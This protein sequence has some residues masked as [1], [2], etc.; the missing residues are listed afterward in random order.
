MIPKLIAFYL[1]QF[2]PFKE[3]DEWW[4]KGFTE[5]TNVT[6]ARPLFAGHYQPHLPTDLGFYDLRVRD[7]RREQIALAKAHGIHGFCYYYYWFSGRRLLDRPVDDMLADRDSDMPFC[8]CWANE[9]WTRT[10][11]G[12]ESDILIAQRHAEGDPE[13]F[14]DDLIP[15]LTDDRYIRVD[16]APF[17]VVYQPAQLPD[18]PGWVRRWRERLR[19]HGIPR[20]HIVCALTHSNWEY[21][22]YGFD[23]AVE[24]PPCNIAD[25]KPL[26][27][28][29]EI[30]GR[31]HNPHFDGI[32]YDYQ[33][34]AR[35]YL[36]RG[37]R[38]PNIFKTVFPSWDNTARRG[39]RAKIMA[40][41]TPANYEFWLKEAVRLTRERFPN[42]ERFVFINAWNEWAEGCHLEPD[43]KYGRAF[44]EATRR[45]IEGRSEVTGFSDLGLE[46]LI[47]GA[48]NEAE[49]LP[50]PVRK[51]FAQR[52]R[53]ETARVVA[54][55]R[56]RTSRARA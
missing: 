37:Y 29:K 8:L 34:I 16:G 39:T 26:L 13:R 33:D 50:R 5:W 12:K 11:N 17:L 4:G 3:N 23:G 7:T 31:R 53:R 1:P 40:N 2:Y 22:S 41:G 28:G 35:A 36:E 48:P 46:S 54:Q 42:E 44:L 52:L 15:Y 45:V 20:V 9:N 18:P 19:F 21:E 56:S 27:K 10:W 25:I 49:A 55:I 30:G 43:R 51:P 32:V 14:I 47:E 38:E 6:K 24:L